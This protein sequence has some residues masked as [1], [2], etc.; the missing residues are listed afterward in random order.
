MATSHLRSRGQALFVFVACDVLLAKCEAVRRHDLLR[1]NPRRLHG[2]RAEPTAAMVN[3]QSVQ[4]SANVA[5]ASQGSDADQKI[6]RKRHLIPDTLGLVLAV[7][8]P[9]LTRPTPPAD[10]IQQGGNCVL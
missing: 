8:S 1:D 6:K 4:T 7:Q 5:E 3:A 2:H 9:S 10:H